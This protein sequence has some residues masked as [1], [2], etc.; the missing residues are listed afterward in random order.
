MG[1]AGGCVVLAEDAEDAIEFVERLSATGLDVLQRSLGELG[2]TI[3]DMVPGTG[4][5]HHHRQRVADRVVEFVSQAGPLLGG[6]GPTSL[7]LHL[8]A[9]TGAQQRPRHHHVHLGEAIDHMRGDRGHE[10]ADERHEHGQPLEALDHL[11]QRID[12]EELFGRARATGAN[13]KDTDT[14]RPV[15]PMT[16]PAIPRGK[17]SSSQK[18]DR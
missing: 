6:L 18:N 8:T 16:K 11:R 14:D 2:I 7:H 9:G 4:L 3:E 12:V 15:I 1:D 13:R 10:D 17:R 5:H